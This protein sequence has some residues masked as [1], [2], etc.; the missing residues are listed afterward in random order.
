[1]PCSFSDTKVTESCLV[2]QTKYHDSPCYCS[3]NY[4]VSNLSEGLKLMIICNV[5]VVLLSKCEHHVY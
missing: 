2:F 3:L 4:L 1:M 5:S